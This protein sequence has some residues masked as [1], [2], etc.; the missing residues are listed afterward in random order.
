LLSSSLSSYT[1]HKQSFCSRPPSLLLSNHE[2]YRM[3]GE[4]GGRRGGRGRRRGDHA[5]WGRA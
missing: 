1:S 5:W 4:G 3:E 2:S